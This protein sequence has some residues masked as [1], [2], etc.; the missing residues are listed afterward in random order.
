LTRKVGPGAIDLIRVCLLVRR[1]ARSTT[2]TST[3]EVY[4]RMRHVRPS[5]SRSSRLAS[6]A[7]GVMAPEHVGSFRD[8]GSVLVT[9]PHAQWSLAG[10]RASRQ[11]SR[12]YIG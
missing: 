4:E 1:S 3:V 7:Y 10:E 2:R 8:E 9:D 5:Q 12:L 11:Q 6:Q